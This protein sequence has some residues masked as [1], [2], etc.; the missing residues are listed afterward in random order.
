MRIVVAIGGNAL[1]RPGQ[2]VSLASQAATLRAVAPDLMAAFTG[3]E[4]V[5]VHGNGPQVGQLAL[6]AQGPEAAWPRPLD[7][8]VAESQGLIGYV[9]ATELGRADPARSCVA[10]L[11]RVRVDRDD[12]AFETPTKPI[13]PIYGAEAA[14]DLEVRRG[15]RFAE[16]AAGWRRVAPS[17]A[18]VE[19]FEI[20]AIESACR[21]GSVT[22]CGGGGGVPVSDDPWGALEGVEAVVDKDATAALIA[23]RLKA[24]RL[25]I[26]TDIDGVYE[27]W[28]RPGQRRLE[29]VE[30]GALAGRRFEAGSMG[31]KVVAACAFA[32]ATGRPA[33]IGAL[34]AAGA[35]IA[36]Q[37]GT[38]VHAASR[39][40]TAG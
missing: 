34:S 31:P 23:I 32:A 19:V 12:P 7:V 30:I 40:Q 21:S 26:L 10:L 28:G 15:W 38:S 39:R 9:I 11:T 18:P 33:V 3:H 17:P 29:R 8:L 22:I 27:D 6:D 13:G 14:H 20:A 2:D 1:I 37:A 16:V 25:V 5:L 24:E 4:V 36:G 35:V